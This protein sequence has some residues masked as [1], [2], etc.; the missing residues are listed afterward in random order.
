MVAALIEH[1][2]RLPGI[3]PRAAERLT[4]HLLKSDAGVSK[5]LASALT[6]LKATV[7]SCRACWNLTQDELCHVCSSMQ[8]DASTLLVVEQPRDLAVIEQAGLYK[9]VYHVLLGRLSPLDGV[10]ADALTID[11]LL[12]RVQSPAANLR[13]A[14]VR[15]V[16]LGLN[17]TFESDGTALYLTEAL[18]KKKIALSRLA[19]GL[20]T[21]VSLEMVN[22]AVLADALSDR[23]PIAAGDNQADRQTTS[24]QAAR[25]R[26]ASTPRANPKE[27]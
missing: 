6:Q 18:S 17:P 21:G 3:G 1:L 12:E 8:R 2:S 27:P 20:P 4:L 11:H 13:G 23:T 14:S 25:A 7:R 24:T 5:D 9:G 10:G 19:R 16:I 15:E 26:S 22:K